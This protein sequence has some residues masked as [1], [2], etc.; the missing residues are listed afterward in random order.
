[1]FCPQCGREVEDGAKFCHGCGYRIEDERKA[2]AFSQGKKSKSGNSAK[3]VLT[4][5]LIAIVAV[6]TALT[7]RHSLLNKTKTIYVNTK[8]VRINCDAP[9]GIPADVKEYEYDELG[10]LKKSTEYFTSY[11]YSST[12]GLS[13]VQHDVYIT[14]Y[15]YDDKGIRN[16]VISYL[17]NVLT[18]EG[19]VQCDKQGRM[20]KY[21]SWDGDTL[22]AK[23]YTYDKN[24]KVLEYWETVNN[25]LKHRTE[26]SYNKNGDMLTTLFYNS[27]GLESSTEYQYDSKGKLTRVLVETYYDDGTEKSIG[28]AGYDEEGTLTQVVFYDDDHEPEEVYEYDAYGN[29]TGYSLYYDGELELRYIYTFEA[30]EVPAS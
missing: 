16:G 13:D 2:I 11:S 6:A 1:M 27:R 22:F 30:M 28:E 10:N 29:V 7:I 12:S 3:L 20:L 15:S 14:M 21:E 17:N 25:E 26:Y 24:G 19:T 18:A 8:T 9:E 23:N 5:A 4:L